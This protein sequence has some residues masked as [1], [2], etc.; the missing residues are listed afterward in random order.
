[1]SRNP[2]LY[3]LWA[4]SLLLVASGIG[5]YA[6]TVDLSLS[7]SLNYASNG[8]EF[9]IADRVRPF[10]PSLLLVGFG[11]AAGLIF[12]SLHHSERLASE[13]DR[14]ADGRAS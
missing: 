3:I 12:L 1:M 7:G 14:A 9:V 13:R 5:L 2:F 10:I 11:T 8:I 6:W 4:L